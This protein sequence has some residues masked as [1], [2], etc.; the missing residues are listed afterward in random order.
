V[1]GTY[2]VSV[3]IDV[4]LPMDWLS[5]TSVVFL[6]AGATG[7]GLT[8]SPD[9]PSTW[10]PET[11]VSTS[12]EL[13]GAEAGEGSSVATA[14]DAE[15]VRTVASDATQTKSTVKAKAGLIAACFLM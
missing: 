1:V 15:A 8:C 7:A 2:A 4:E 13:S 11:G 9:V 3:A 14:G 12:F 6:G 5:A 10:L